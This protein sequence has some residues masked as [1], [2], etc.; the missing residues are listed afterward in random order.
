MKLHLM[1]T[2]NE[3]YNHKNQSQRHASMYSE[4]I[5]QLTTDVTLAA[6]RHSYLWILPVYKCTKNIKGFSDIKP[7]QPK[8]PVS[9]DHQDDRHD[10]PSLSLSSLTCLVLIPNFLVTVD[11]NHNEPQLQERDQHVHH[12][13]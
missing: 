4:F 5:H 7:T 6:P 9:S 1:D 8:L 12:Y 3:K 2:K 10:L 11:Q 13:L